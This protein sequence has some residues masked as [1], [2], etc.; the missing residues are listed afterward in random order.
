VSGGLLHARGGEAKSL[1]FVATTTAN[2]EVGCYDLD[3]RLALRRADDPQGMA[4]V[5]A[6]VAIPESVITIEPASVLYVD[7]KGARW[8]LPKGDP[9]FDQPG[10]LGAGRVCRE[11]CTERNLL[12]VHGTFY[13]LPSDNAGGFAKVRPIT[14]HNRRIQDFASYRGFLVLSG[15]SDNAKGGRIIRSD[16]GRCALWVGVVDDLW[17]FGKPRGHGGPWLDSPVKAGQPSDAYLATGYDRKRLTLSHQSPTPVSFRVEADFTGTG[18]WTEVVTL[19]V[20]SGKRTEYRFPAAF[21]AYWLRIVPA[22]DA[23]ATAQFEYD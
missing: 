6:N 22:A 10:P 16:D 19:A 7:D 15:I 14:T 11:V 5:K 1:H 20:A 8:R 2:G 18:V 12:N 3:D 9:A 17:S 4:W 23:M 21:G 13:E